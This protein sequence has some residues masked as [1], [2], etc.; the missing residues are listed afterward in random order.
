MANLWAL[1]T[2]KVNKHTFSQAQGK[3]FLFKQ[4][5]TNQTI[6]FK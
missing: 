4:N 1:T 2:V 6:H 3:H 5:K